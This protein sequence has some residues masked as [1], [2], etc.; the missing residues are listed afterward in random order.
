MT[1]KKPTKKPNPR[2]KPRRA[3]PPAQSGAPMR[4]DLS[5]IIDMIIDAKERGAFDPK[6]RPRTVAK[7]TV[8]NT[9]GA[10]FARIV[11]GAKT[12]DQQ[13][14]ALEAAAQRDVALPADAFVVGEPITAAAI[15]YSGHPRAGLTLWGVRGDRRFSVGLADVAFPPGSAG[16]RFVSLYRAWLGFGELSSDPE[17]RSAAPA[18]RHKVTGEEIV[19]GSPVELVV[20]ACKSNAL[21]CRLLGT[22]REVTLRTAVR[23]EVPGA[24]ITVMPTKQWTHARHAYLAG[25]VLAMRADVEALGLPPLAVHEQGEWDPETEYWGEEGEPIEDWAKPII[26]R[27]KRPMFEMEQVLP[28]TDPEDFD[29]DPIVEASELNAMGDRAGAREVLMKLLAQDLRCLDAHAHLGNFAFDRSPLEAQRHYEIGMS[30]GAFSLGKKF[31]GVLAWGLIDNRPFL[32]CM[33]GVGLCAWRLGQTR[34]AAAVFRK[35]LWLNP[36][37]NQGARFNLAAVEAGKTWD[38]MEGDS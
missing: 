6:N 14:R 8:S 32:R 36:S 11:A 19:V 25:N 22:A 35:M 29:S 37:D 12:E 21:R 23:E 9:P 7:P 4:D 33:L 17:L 27:G 2:A 31:D 13:L 30:I 20:L 38:E 15:T 26:A 18:A 1:T 24:I 16:A 3:K 10:P 34:E 28:G 5:A